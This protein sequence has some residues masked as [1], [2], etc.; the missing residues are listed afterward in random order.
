MPEAVTVTTSPP[1]L[2]GVA[3]TYNGSTTPPTGAGSYAVVASMSNASFTASNVSGTLVINPATPVFSNLTAPE[4]IASGTATVT[5]G[6]NLTAGSLPATGSVAVTLG[7]VQRLAS[8]DSGG[9]FS[10]TFNTATLA[11]SVTAYPVSYSYAATTDFAAAS[12]TA[13]TAVTVTGNTTSAA[14][15]TS[16]VTVIGL[17]VTKVKVGTGRHAQKSLVLDVHFS[18]ALSTS[19]A[20]NVNLYTVY[21]GITKK[22]HKVSQT[23]YNSLV[24]LTQAI[25]APSVNSVFL[26]PRGKHKLPKLEQ[27]HVN[28]SLLTDPMGR[29]INNGKSFTAT[30][31]NTGLVISAASASG[32]PDASSSQTSESRLFFRLLVATNS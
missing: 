25:Y 32:T 22:V 23:V 9:N 8:L 4:T 5:L 10:T 20:Q 6:G 1:G 27:L 30:T 16:P 19:A 24:P 29:S 3:V 15:L 11:A 28:V 31:T 2:S 17:T 13:A 18:G 21:S 14:N 7:G 26:L 12:T